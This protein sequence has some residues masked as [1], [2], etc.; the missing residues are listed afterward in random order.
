MPINDIVNKILLIIPE[1]IFISQNVY[2]QG[3]L[4]SNPVVTPEYLELSVETSLHNESNPY[5]Y[6]NTEV[7]P[8]TNLTM[9]Y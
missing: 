7:L 6:N 8:A 9:D 2:L 5:P 4:K 3:L 1:D